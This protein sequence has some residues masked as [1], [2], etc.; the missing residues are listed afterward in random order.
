MI[1]CL[2]LD[3]LNPN[4]ICKLFQSVLLACIY[5]KQRAKN[6]KQHLKKKAQT[7]GCLHTQ[8]YKA[9]RPIEIHFINK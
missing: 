9:V 7:I 8:V 5:Y 4:D 3:Q 6:M 1:C 2:Q